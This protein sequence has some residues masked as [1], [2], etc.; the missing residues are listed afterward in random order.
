MRVLWLGDANC[1]SGFARC[2]HAV[3]DELHEAGWDV[4]VL[5]VNHYGDSHD[6]PY[7]IYSCYHPLDKGRDTFGVS[8]LPHLTYNLKPD[9]VVLLTDPWNVP[10]YLEELDGLPDD[11]ERPPVVAWL[12]VDAMNQNA[13]PLNALDHVVV[14]TK[15][16]ADELRAGGYEGQTSVVPLGVDLDVYHP[17]DRATSRDIVMPKGIPKHAFIAG[18]VGRNQPRKRLDLTLAYFAEWGEKDAWLYLHVAPTGD[19]GFNLLSLIKY[20]GLGGRVILSQPH[21]GR[22]IANDQMPWV[23]SALNV[24]WSTTQGE[25]WGLPTLEAMACGVP[26]AVPDFAGLG[27]WTG[28]AALKVPCTG[29]AINAPLNAQAYTVGRVPDEKGM[30]WALNSLHK[31]GA[32]REKYANRGLALAET[33]SWQRTGEL[34]RA[35][36][37]EVC[38]VEPLRVMEGYSASP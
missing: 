22:G 31:D 20:Y 28:D 10:I 2:T 19:H 38:G 33:L 26:C 23:Y 15:F 37:E 7:P 34:F 27:D 1:S 4:N 3:C 16:A 32:L 14:W 12:A 13:E 24:Y 17:R 8:R 36:V 6:Y 29:S 25:G 11:F 9:L 5:G 35:V 18:V 30:V 21:V